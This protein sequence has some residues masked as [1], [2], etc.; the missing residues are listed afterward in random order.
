MEGTNAT[1]PDRSGAFTTAWQYNSR[2][3]MLLS[4]YAEDTF[5]EAYFDAYSV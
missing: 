4:M 5:F 1:S 2:D 3:E